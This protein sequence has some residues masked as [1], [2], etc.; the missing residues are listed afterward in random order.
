[1]GEEVGII[2]RDYWFKIVD[3]LQQNWVHVDVEADGAVVFFYWDTSGASDRLRFDD[4]LE[5][6]SAFRR[7]GFN[8]N[9][10]DSEGQGFIAIPQPPFNERSHPNG[11]IYS[12]GRYCLSLLQ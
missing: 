5:P 4:F 12:S 9:C 7:N 2:G 3:F 10:E 8:R 1:M 11:P 6:E